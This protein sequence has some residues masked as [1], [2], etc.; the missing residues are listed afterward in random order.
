MIIARWLVPPEWLHLHD[1]PAA[2]KDYS[3]YTVS[4]YSGATI[5]G[6]HTMEG[7]S[8]G[9]NDASDAGIVHRMIAI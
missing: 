2:H 6:W 1:T 9:H 4:K 7:T 3:I 5:K 8:S